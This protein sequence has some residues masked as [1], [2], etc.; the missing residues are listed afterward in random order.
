M[1]QESKDLKPSD[2]SDSKPSGASLGKLIQLENNHPDCQSLEVQ[3]ALDQFFSGVSERA[4]TEWL[5]RKEGLDPSSAILR[6]TP[7]KAD[8]AHRSKM[9]LVEPV[10]VLFNL[11]EHYRDRLQIDGKG[12]ASAGRVFE[13]KP[14]S[15][16]PSAVT[17]DPGTLHVDM[18]GTSRTT[19]DAE[20]EA[21]TFAD[22][23]IKGEFGSGHKALEYKD[24]K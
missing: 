2:I 11:E 8:E 1:P 23:D 16:F 3:I 7:M 19:V 15:Q 18:N 5:A 12:S 9:S 4:L 17:P 10:D 24:L 14:G 6:L 22:K 20:Y 21:F 13:S